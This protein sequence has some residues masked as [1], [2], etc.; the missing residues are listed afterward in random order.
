MTLSLWW[1]WWHLPR[2]Q[3]YRAKVRRII[4]RLCFI[5]LNRD[6][7]SYTNS[8]PLARIILWWLS[9]LRRYWPSIS[10]RGICP[11]RF[12]KRLKELW[13]GFVLILPVSLLIFRHFESRSLVQKHHEPP[14]HTKLSCAGQCTF[15][16]HWICLS[17]PSFASPLTNI[18][19]QLL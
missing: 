17:A 11:L 13:H 18:W 1:W 16:L 10:L 5:F 7:M 8:A 15:C 19:S 14:T 2:T 4:P 9:E 3:G 6:Q 12:V